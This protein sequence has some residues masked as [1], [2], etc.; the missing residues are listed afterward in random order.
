MARREIEHHVYS[1]EQKSEKEYFLEGMTRYPAGHARSHL[2][3]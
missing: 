2:T 1:R 3:A